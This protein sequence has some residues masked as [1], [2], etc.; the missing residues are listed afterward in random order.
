[1]GDQIEALKIL[2][3]H[4]NVEPNIFFKIKTRKRTRGHDFMLVKGRGFSKVFVFSEDSKGLCKEKL[5]KSEFT[6]EVGGWVQV[7]LKFLCGKSSQNSS[8]PVL[9][10]WSSIPRVFC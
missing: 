10:F 4:E 8:K 9:I 7:S 3:G 2:N 5:K 6:M 1:M